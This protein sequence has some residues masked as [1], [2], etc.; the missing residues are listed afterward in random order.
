MEPPTPPPHAAAVT[1]LSDSPV[2]V[3]RS[4]SF[5]FDKFGS[6]VGVKAKVEG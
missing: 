4:G 6:S 5:G 1:A 2:F 3:R